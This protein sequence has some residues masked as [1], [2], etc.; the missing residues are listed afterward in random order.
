VSCSITMRL[1]MV[2]AAVQCDLE[3]QE[4]LD[5]DLLDCA[6][7]GDVERLELLLTQFGANVHATDLFG[8]TVCRAVSASPVLPGFDGGCLPPLT[9]LA[10]W[11]VSGRI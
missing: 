4:E 11:T 2:E 9:E 8:Q 7:N 1:E 5:G 6:M 3:I 10:T